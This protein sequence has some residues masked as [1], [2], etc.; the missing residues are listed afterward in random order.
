MDVEAN[1]KIGKFSKMAKLEIYAATGNSVK[2]ENW[3][4]KKVEIQQNWTTG[5][6]TNQDLSVE[7]QQNG[8][9]MKLHCQDAGEQDF[10]K[11][12]VCPSGT[13]PPRHSTNLEWLFLY[14]HSFSSSKVH[15]TSS[16][17]TGVSIQ[18]SKS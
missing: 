14:T 10:R 17:D 1:R 16:S 7:K 3:K 4:F 6:S 8:N 13:I 11:A 15:T 5:N 9:P 18:N 2:L 12:T